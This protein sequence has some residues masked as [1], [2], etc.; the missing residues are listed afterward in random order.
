M[1]LQIIELNGPIMVVDEVLKKIDKA[2][3]DVN[4]KALT[5][6]TYGTL[7]VC[8]TLFLYTVKF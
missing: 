1:N 4:I 7:Y 6:H 8:L 2:N 5:D 3:N